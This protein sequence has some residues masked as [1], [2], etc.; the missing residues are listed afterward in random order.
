MDLT[1]KLKCTVSS[2]FLHYVLGVTASKTEVSDGL[3][4]ENTNDNKSICLV[5][6]R[7]YTEWTTEKCTSDKRAFICEQKQPDSSSSRLDGSFYSPNNNIEITFINSF[8]KIYINI[9]F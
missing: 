9:C 1:L 5:S 8:C 6:S 7:G 2:L 4:E 3:I